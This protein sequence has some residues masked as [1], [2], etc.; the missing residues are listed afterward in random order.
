METQTSDTR[1]E[2]IR[3]SVPEWLAKLNAEAERRYNAVDWQQ[4]KWYAIYE[5]DEGSPASALLFKCEI[6][7]QGD[8]Y[9]VGDQCDWDRRGGHEPDVYEARGYITSRSVVIPQ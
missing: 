4:G 6:D 3:A 2:E 8:V 1:S 5:E 7:Q 9:L